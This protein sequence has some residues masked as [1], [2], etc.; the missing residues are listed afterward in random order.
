[1]PQAT[2]TIMSTKV[3]DLVSSSA[4]IYPASVQ[5]MTQ[6]YGVFA[7]LGAGYWQVTQPIPT[8][9]RLDDFLAWARG[10]H[11]W[12][13]ALLFLLAGLAIYIAVLTVHG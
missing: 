4:T 9:S 8:R 3:V 7:Q 13:N 1:M 11:Y 6:L 12:N 5:V 2:T 10:D